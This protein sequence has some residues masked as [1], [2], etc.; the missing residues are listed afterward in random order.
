M[1][2]TP[3]KSLI[4]LPPYWPM[5]DLHCAICGVW[6]GDLVLGRLLHRLTRGHWWL[7]PPV[8]GIL[9]TSRLLTEAEV[10]AIRRRWEQ[11]FAGDGLHHAVELGEE[12][13]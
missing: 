13:K 10:E 6:C 7:C 3:P 5:G 4:V 9:T 11:Q 1:V 12:S 2:K 8:N